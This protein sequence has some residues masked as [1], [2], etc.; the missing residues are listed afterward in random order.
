MKKNFPSHWMMIEHDFHVEDD[1]LIPFALEEVITREVGQTG[2]PAVH[3]WTHPRGFVMGLR[4]RR[5]PGAVQAMSGL[6]QEGRKVIVRHS[7][8]AA[9]PLHDG[10]LNVS[11]IH[12]K[13]TGSIDFHHDFKVMVEFLAEACQRLG[14]RFEVGEIQGSY[15]PGDYDLAIGGRKFCGIAQRRQTKAY[16]VHA[17]IVVS[18]SGAELAERVRQFYAE[19]SEGDDSLSYPR[20][21]PAQTASLN[22]L[23]EG[24]IDTVDTLKEAIRQTVSAHADR[25]T[26]HASYASIEQPILEQTEQMMEQLR[27][28]YEKR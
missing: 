11:F 23:T 24:R 25:L 4:D 28:R 1:L 27:Q 26:M 6:E 2:I 21:V 5:L 9:V 20:I 10:V 15:C 3:M 12:P 7:G 13:P 22:E 8:G 14:V 17:F 19:A 16:L 18:G